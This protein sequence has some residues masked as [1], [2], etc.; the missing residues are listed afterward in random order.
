MEHM[1]NINNNEEIGA[2]SVQEKQVKKLV[3]F[4]A[5]GL[6]LLRKMSE[7]LESIDSSIEI[8]GAQKARELSPEQ[9]DTEAAE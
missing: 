2:E 4:A 1:K 8:F 9:P 7:T 3:V 5:I 6:K